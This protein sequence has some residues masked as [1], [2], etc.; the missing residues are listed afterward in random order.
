MYVKQ[1]LR[2]R[3]I[4]GH[5]RARNFSSPEE[6][7][8]VLLSDPSEERSVQVQIVLGRVDVYS[9]KEEVNRSKE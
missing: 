7:S 8:A 3:Y 6:L 2:A 5:E 1:L 9:I 4:H